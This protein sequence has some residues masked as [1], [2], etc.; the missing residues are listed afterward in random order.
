MKELVF[1]LIS[2]FFHVN[3]YEHRLRDTAYYQVSDGEAQHEVVERISDVLVRSF[4]DCET[5]KQVAWNCYQSEDKRDCGDTVRLNGRRR[6]ILVTLI[7]HACRP[8]SENKLRT[9]CFFPNSPTSKR[10]PN[11]TLVFLLFTCLF[12]PILENFNK[13]TNLLRLT[14]EGLYNK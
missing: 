6:K 9:N 5:Y 1:D 14:V 4:D 10:S 13:R 3:V 12:L 8:L 2:R 7:K 11:R